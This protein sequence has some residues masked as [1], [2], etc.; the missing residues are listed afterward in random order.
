VQGPDVDRYGRTVAT[1]AVGLQDIGAAMVRQRWAVDNE[2]Y[3]GGAYA[4]EQLEAE[5]AERGPWSGSFVAPREWRARQ[6]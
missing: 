6:N 2:W 4:A 3:S 1:C 5:Q